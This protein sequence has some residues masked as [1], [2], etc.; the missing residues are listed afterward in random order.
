MK[1]HRTHPKLSIL[2]IAL[3]NISGLMVTEF[4]IKSL[5]VLS[6]ISQLSSI[7][8]WGGGG[9]GGENNAPPKYCKYWHLQ[10]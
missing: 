9:G 4:S 5:F 7:S 2:K 6:V 8:S 10:K 1:H 3:P